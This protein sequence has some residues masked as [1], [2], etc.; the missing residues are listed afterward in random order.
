MKNYRIALIITLVWATGTGTATSAGTLNGENSGMAT[1]NVRTSGQLRVLWQP[2]SATLIAGNWSAGNN[3]AQLAI[4]VVGG[5]PNTHPAAR[6]TDPYNGQATVSNCTSCR[7][8]SATEGG[9]L[10]PLKLECAGA[11]AEDDWQYASAST[12]LSCT[13]ATSRQATVTAGSYTISLDAAMRT[14]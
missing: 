12:S 7:D 11:S 14:E 8:V 3:V 2:T 10:M 9:G 13:I 4:E 6:W 5:S 1:V